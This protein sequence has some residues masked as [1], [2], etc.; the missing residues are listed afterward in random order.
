[1]PIPTL[2]EIYYNGIDS[3]PYLLPILKVVPWILAVVILKIYFNGYRNRNERVM[4]GKVAI[5]TGGTS[6]VGAAVVNDLAARGMHLVLLVRNATDVFTVDYIED[7]RELHGNPFIYA[8]ECDLSSLHSIRLFAT[9]FIDNTPPRRLDMVICCA[10]VMAP[11]YTPRTTTKD[12]IE[13]HWGLNF[14]AN[15]QLLNILAPCMRAQPPDRDVRILLATCSSYIA[16][17]LDLN[18]PQFFR[19]KYPLRTPWLC[20]GASKMALMAFCL[21]FQR[22]LDSYVRPDKQPNNVRIYNIDPGLVRTPGARRWITMGS[23]WGL[24]VY[25]VTWPIWWLVLK[26]PQQGAQSFLAAAMSPE[27][28][29]GEGGKFLRE[30]QNQKYRA[31]VLASSELGKQLWEIAELMI[32]DAEKAGAIKRAKEKGKKRAQEDTKDE[33]KPDEENKELI[34]KIRQRK[35]ALRKISEEE[36]AKEHEERAKAKLPPSFPPLPMDTPSRGTR[37][38]TEELR[39]GEVEEVPRVNIETKDGVQDTPSRNTRRRTK[40][41]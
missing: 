32:K 9:K 35:E 8:E 11:P 38:R 30:C 4:H 17:D 14:L 23:L 31:D 22:R 39:T 34:E 36:E 5:I 1:M 6:G 25:L 29:M 15:Y 21:E 41:A 27:C 13:A 2:G 10:G 16:G 7:L 18:D 20:Y 26:D 37:S 19:R 28:G 40:K 12:G 33:P 3:V 24:G